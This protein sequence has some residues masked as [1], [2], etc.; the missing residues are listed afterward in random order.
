MEQNLLTVQPV[1]LFPW[2]HVV[3]SQR[4]QGWL[5]A[6]LGRLQNAISEGGCQM[7]KI[8]YVYESGEL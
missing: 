7:S 2:D 1:V 8:W 3:E 4:D 6:V 5:S